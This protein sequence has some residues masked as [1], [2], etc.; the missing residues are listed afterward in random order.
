L[1]AIR[2]LRYLS[3][4]GCYSVGGE[5]AALDAQSITPFLL[6][7]S[8]LAMLF[9]EDHTQNI[10][11][12]HMGPDKAKLRPAC[13]RARRR[14]LSRSSAGV[15]SPNDRDR[16]LADIASCRS[17]EQKLVA[18]RATRSGATAIT[19]KFDLLGRT[20]LEDKLAPQ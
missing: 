7:A 9:P 19:V 20:V 1:A 16:V 12:P 2:K 17:V 18:F 6:A 3:R 14:P 11:V 13:R 10:H 4:C 8:L 15:I 5:P